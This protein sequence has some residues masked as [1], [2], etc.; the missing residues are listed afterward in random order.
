M[1]LHNTL[2][3]AKNISE[4]NARSRVSAIIAVR[5]P[6][7]CLSSSIKPKF[8]NQLFVNLCF[9]YESCEPKIVLSVPQINYNFTSQFVQIK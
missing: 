9:L 8:D 5:I 6:D 4:A 3:L 2:T 1:S 7:K